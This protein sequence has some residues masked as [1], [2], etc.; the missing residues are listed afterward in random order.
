VWMF[1]SNASQGKDIAPLCDN[2]TF[3]S[4]SVYTSVTSISNVFA[5]DT[6]FFENPAFSVPFRG[7]NKYFAFKAPAAGEQ[8]ADQGF[9][10]GW[11]QI[12]NSGRVVSFREC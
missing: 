5:N 12:D 7:N 8:K 6:L 1:S 10:Q 11:L 9:L 4:V 3:C 2:T